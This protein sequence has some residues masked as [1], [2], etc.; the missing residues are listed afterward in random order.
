M[1]VLE[2]FIVDL[3]TASDAQLAA[4]IAGSVAASAPGGA[5]VTADQTAAEQTLLARLAPRV[6]LYGLRHLRDEQAAADLVQQVLLIVLESLRDGRVN[7]PE[8]LVSFVLGT[9]RMVVMDQ[10]RGAQRRQKLLEKYPNEFPTTEPA[11]EGPVD[12]DVLERCLQGLAERELS[13]ISMSYFEEQ[14]SA[15]VGASLG[16]SEANV[17]VI[18]HR[19]LG[20][21]RNCMT[22]GVQ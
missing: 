21:L 9:C 14:G 13:V 15:V 2:S 6:R 10:R 7:D 3:H 8:K 11:R 17:R 20:R 1:A 18:R 22:G 12:L 5:T 4:V 19:A 16:L